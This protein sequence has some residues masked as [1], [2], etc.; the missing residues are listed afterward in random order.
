MGKTH[1]G[2]S[3]AHH[4]WLLCGTASTTDDPHG[5]VPAPR[6]CGKTGLAAALPRCPG[7]GPVRPGRHRLRHRPERRRRGHRHR[8]ASA[9]HPRCFRNCSTVHRP[10]TRR[11]CGSCPALHPWIFQ[12]PRALRSTSS[13]R[14]SPPACCR[15][16]AGAPWHTGPS[17]WSLSRHWGWSACCAARVLNR[18]AWARPPW[19]RGIRFLPAP[20]GASDNTK[21]PADTLAAHSPCLT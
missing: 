6:F 1:E 9:H 3:D 16:P 12:A 10:P 15:R 7:A 5:P 14:P 2:I 8:P 21:P 19:S 4:L 20:F 13:P 18:I 11:R 17:A